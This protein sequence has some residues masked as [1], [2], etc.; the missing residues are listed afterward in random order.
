M[1][2][3]LCLVV[4]LRNC[5]EM[6]LQRSDDEKFIRTNGVDPHVLV[7]RLDLFHPATHVGASIDCIAGWL[8]G[9]RIGVA[10]PES[11]R[12]I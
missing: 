11:I 9:S 12:N 10:T 2:S 6:F 7:A 4:A 5:V 3:K 1:V 8:F